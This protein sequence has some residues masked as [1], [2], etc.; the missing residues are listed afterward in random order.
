MSLS[1]VLSERVACSMGF[2]VV[3]F[4]EGDEEDISEPWT[5]LL[6]L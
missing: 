1:R 5:L 2:L 4:C 6:Q 3:C